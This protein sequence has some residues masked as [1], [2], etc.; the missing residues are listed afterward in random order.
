MKQRIILTAALAIFAFL[1]GSKAFAQLTLTGEVRP[2]TEYR[3]GFKKLINEG[4]EGALFTEQ[5]T[6]FIADF[7]QDKLL[8][9]VSIQDVRIWGATDQIYKSDPALSAF[10]EAWAQYSFTKEFSLKAGRQEL[11]Y[12]NARF[13]GNLGWAQQSRSHDVLLF[14]YKDSTFQAHGGLAFNQD[15]NT[16]EFK[17]LTSTYYSGVNNYK[18]MQYAWLNKTFGKHSL[19][20]L[21]L[22]NGLQ[23]G[24]A[25]STESV[26]YSQTYGLYGKFKPGSIVI[27][28]EA[29]Y[30]GGKDAADK[31]VNAYLLSANIGYT[32]IKKFKPFIGFDYLSGTEVDATENNSFAPLYG[33]NHKFYGFMDYF[34]VGNPHGNAGLI[35]VFF[36]AAFPFSKKVKALAH[37]HSF[38]SPTKVFDIAG[39]ELSSG[40][41]TEVDLVL[42][43]NLSSSANLKM[44]YS[45]MFATSTMEAIKGGSKDEINNWA[46]LMLTFKP[47][48]FKSK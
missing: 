12:D 26:N 48:L 46:W 9:K 1:G 42:N 16:P 15:A 17:K 25:D 3:H 2:R 4:E 7:K 36:K 5:R 28:G 23:T 37:V 44:G 30:Q 18:S 6:R 43:L 29:Y 19:S 8:F 10:N 21:L 32:G 35:D 41:G 24:I 47:T 40:L 20:F 33:T 31:S 13:L 39:E 34:Y 38:Y 14:I 11:N 22:N 27:E 45:Q